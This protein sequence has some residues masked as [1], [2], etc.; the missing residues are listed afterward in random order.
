MSRNASE[1][2]QGTSTTVHGCEFLFTDLRALL[3][4]RKSKYRRQAPINAYLKYI[5]W[6]G[7][8][9]G[10]LRRGEQK[11]E[12]KKCDFCS[13]FSSGLYAL[14]IFKR[15]LQVFHGATTQR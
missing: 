14:C 15:V 7:G 5:R 12:G 10:I 13:G 4:H 3:G 8:G 1:G 9:Q 2:T 6:Q 11:L